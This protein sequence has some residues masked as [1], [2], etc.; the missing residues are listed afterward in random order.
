MTKQ[1]LVNL[2]ADRTGQ[3]KTLVDGILSNIVDV[4]K[5]EVKS[6]S[7]I[8]IRGFGKFFAYESKPR[9]GRDFKS[10]KT[11]DIPS[12]AKMKFKAF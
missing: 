6:G 10:G 11:I 2:V 12:K 9:K 8:T 3:S 4:V 5:E 7:T 1:D